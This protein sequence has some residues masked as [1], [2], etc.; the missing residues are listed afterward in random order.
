[1]LPALKKYLLLPKLVKLSSGAPKDPG[2]AWDQYWGR[3]EATGARGDVLWDSGS[4]HELQGYLEHLTRQL[5]PSLPLVDVGCGS[6]VFSRALAPYFPHV[7]G[8]DVSANAVARAAA[9][10]AG[11]ERVSYLAADMTAPAGIGAVAEAL[12]VA[13]F[14]GEANVFIRGVLHVLKRPAQSALAGQL[15]RLVGKQGR[16]FLAETDFRGNPIQYV[17]HLGATP[18]FI[19][20]P[21]EKAIRAL[22]VPG[23]FGA[24][25]R[26]RAFSEASWDVVEDGPVTIETRPLTSPDRPEQIPGYFAVLQAR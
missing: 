11:V 12:A 18:H 5:D 21:L 20:E 13:G 2:V 23:R 25:Q 10:S 14:P 9:E 17:S 26:R 3:V 24:Q 7:L 22:P 16:V 6:G 8:V 1:M 4:D 15:H 19:P